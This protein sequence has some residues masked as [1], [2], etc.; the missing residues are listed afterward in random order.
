MTTEPVRAT[1]VAPPKPAPWLGSVRAAAPG[2]VEAFEA[3]P[4]EWFV[5]DLVWRKNPTGRGWLPVNR[6][7][8]PETWAELVAT[9]DFVVTQ[10]DDGH[11]TLP[12]GIGRA[13]TSSTSMPTMM[14]VML[15]TL[16]LPTDLHRRN[17][18]G[19]RVLEIGTGTGWNTA[20]LA[21]RLGVGNV[22]SIE[23]DPQI[24]DHARAAL[25][26]TG[27]PVTVI[28]GD[29]EQAPPASDHDHALYDRVISTAAC[30][31]VPYTW[32]QQCK[33]GGIIVTPW[34]TPYLGSALL[35]LTV[36]HST[37]TDAMASG[38]FIEHASFMPLRA[39]RGGDW[40]P[41]P[42]TE[43]DAA[44]SATALHPYEPV[45]D[46][47]GCA[48]TVSLLVP[49]LEKSIAFPDPHDQH[50]YEVLL[51]EAT[52][53]SWATITVTPAALH[54]D[55]YLVRQHGQRRLWDEIEAAY[56]WWEHHGHPTYTQF[57]LTIGATGQRAWLDD[58]S[59]PL[60][61]ITPPDSRA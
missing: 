39:Q 28:T 7:M 2:W 10:V 19:L 37:T 56:T 18:P 55:I 23:I 49:D 58:P 47:D 32:V 9:D 43:P 44:E 36:T 60:G 34:Q 31:R 13:V 57:G 61:P 30:H 26:S 50:T 52:S 17:G 51:F 29:G 14:A 22:T 24:A 1:A 25:A 8:E 15:H 46:Y 33:P 12:G 53:R 5:P 48:F 27:Y 40:I 20:L 42:D 45:S 35:Q 16:N 38:R 41:D 21:H 54:T 3:A 6:N 11:P 59:Q 4:R